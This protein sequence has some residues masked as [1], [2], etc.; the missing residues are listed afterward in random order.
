MLQ[1]TVEKAI[2]LTRSFSDYNQDPTCFSEVVLMDVLEGAAMTRGSL[3]GTKGITFDT[4]IDPSVSGA[5]LQGDPYLLDL[6]IGHLLQNALESTN[7]GGR[8]ILQ[9]SVKR[10]NDVA[11]VARISIKDSGCGIEQNVLSNVI[12]PFFS[13][14]KNHDGLGLSMASRFID[15]HGGILRITSVEGKGT[16]VDIVLP[17]NLETQS[18]LL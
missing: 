15:I 9:A 11:P 3:F 5:T 8:V 6:A 4:Q 10:A 14:K 12:V 1:E 16:D 18:V 17:I 2:E 7:A 13:S